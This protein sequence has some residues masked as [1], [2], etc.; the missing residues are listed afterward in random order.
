MMS[1]N[2]IHNSKVSR[3]GQYHEASFKSSNSK[4]KR[5]T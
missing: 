4:E 2:N 3:A 1:L 5:K